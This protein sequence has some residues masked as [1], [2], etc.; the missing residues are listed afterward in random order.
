M[1]EETEKEAAGDAAAF[2]GGRLQSLEW[3]RQEARS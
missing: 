1:Q 2:A 3:H